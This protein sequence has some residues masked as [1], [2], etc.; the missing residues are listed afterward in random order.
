EADRPAEGGSCH[1]TPSDPIPLGIWRDLGP[2]GM[3]TVGRR[4]RDPGPRH[5]PAGRA[6]RVPVGRT[7]ASEGCSQEPSGIGVSGQ[8]RSRAGETFHAQETFHG[9]FYYSSP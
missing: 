6:K 9:P 8:S 5:G 1:D 7:L 2:E 3:T 4:G